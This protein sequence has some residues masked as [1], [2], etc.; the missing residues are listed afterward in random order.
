[1]KDCTTK[2]TKNLILTLNGNS[3]TQEYFGVILGMKL[4][5]QFFKLKKKMRATPWKKNIEEKRAAISP[6]QTRL[7]ATFQNL[8]QLLNPIC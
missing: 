5:Q 3:K 7:D 8:N 1:M 4:E 6:Q 2:Y